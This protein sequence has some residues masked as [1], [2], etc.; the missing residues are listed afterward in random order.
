MST[1]EMFYLGLVLA[2]FVEKT[3]PTIDAIE[4]SCFERLPMPLG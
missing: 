4:T 1:V 2:G 3:C